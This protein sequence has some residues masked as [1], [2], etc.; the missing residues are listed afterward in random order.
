LFICLSTFIDDRSA[1]AVDQRR[2]AELSAW[3]ASGQV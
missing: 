3:I 2:A 1:P